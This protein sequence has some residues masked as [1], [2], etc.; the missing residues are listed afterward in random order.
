MSANNLES[1]IAQPL[2]VPVHPPQITSQTQP[3]TRIGSDANM[4]LDSLIF[5]PGEAG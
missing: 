1:T 3:I 4:L 2:D 5:A